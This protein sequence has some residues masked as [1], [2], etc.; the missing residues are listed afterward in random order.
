MEAEYLRQKRREFLDDTVMYYSADVSRRAVVAID[1]PKDGEPK[2]ACKYRT[3]DGRKCAVG[4][5]V[6]DDAY[7]ILMEGHS[8]NTE[9]MKK[10]LP[11][12]ILSLGIDFLQEIQQLHDCDDN[13]NDKG[14]SLQGKTVAETMMSQYCA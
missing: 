7:D 2:S 1:G 8:I 6:H 14:I 10:Y 5:H 11:E 4:R 3:S 13:W 9:A 12:K